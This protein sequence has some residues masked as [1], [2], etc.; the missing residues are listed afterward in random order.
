MSEKDAGKVVD[1]SDAGRSDYLRRFYGEKA[2][3]PEQYDV[4]VNT[5]RLSVDAAVEIVSGAAGAR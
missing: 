4:V 5:D 2:E 1:E 3:L